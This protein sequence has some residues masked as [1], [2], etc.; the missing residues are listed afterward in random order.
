[1]LRWKQTNEHTHK[2]CIPYLLGT[3]CLRKSSI[4]TAASPEQSDTGSYKR[5]LGITRD[6]N[7]FPVLFHKSKIIM[8]VTLAARVYFSL[9]R[10]CLHD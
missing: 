8:E 10:V 6:A 7:S 1:M 3:T 4:Q 2:I 5:P 9:L